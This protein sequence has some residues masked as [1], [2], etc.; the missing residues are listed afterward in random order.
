[1]TVDKDGYHLASPYAD[2]ESWDVLLFDAFGTNSQAVF[3]AFL[4]Q[5]TSLLPEK[6]DEESERWVPEETDL[7]FAIEFVQSIKPKTEFEA[8]LAAQMLAVHL[9]TMNQAEWGVRG[10]ERAAATASRLARTYAMQV[11]PL[12]L[13]RG[14]GK[15]SK[16]TIKVIQKKEI[17]NHQ[18]VHIGGS[19]ENGEQP[20][21]S[22]GTGNAEKCTA[23]PGKNEARNIVPIA[24]D[25][26]KEK[27]PAPRRQ[28]P[29]RAKR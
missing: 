18:H 23:L 26:R 7:A 27:V 8:A 5:I 25:E 9:M 22:T 1:L 17:H 6:W 13:L 21:E 14:K 10:S 15:K 11:E 12:R 29:R 2:E 24:G 20:H 19:D 3:G 28:K 4:D 16:Q